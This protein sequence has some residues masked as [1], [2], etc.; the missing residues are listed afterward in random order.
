MEKKVAFGNLYLQ[1]PDNNT[2]KYE[3]SEQYTKIGSSKQ[4]SNILIEK[5]LIDFIHCVIKYN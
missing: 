5:P 2:V 1:T 4:Y 3:L